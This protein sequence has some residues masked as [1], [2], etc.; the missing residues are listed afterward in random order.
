M[1]KSEFLVQA[2]KSG[3]KNLSV[4]GQIIDISG[5]TY[6][7][8]PGYTPFVEGECTIVA[9]PANYNNVLNNDRKTKFGIATIKV[10]SLGVLNPYLTT[11]IVFEKNKDL[12]QVGEKARFAISQTEGVN[13]AGKA[14]FNVQH[15]LTGRT[16]IEDL[17]FDDMG[18]DATID[19]A[20]N[21]EMAEK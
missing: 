16:T 13:E 5:L 18:K 6:H 1:T 17:L 10:T 8:N 12:I 9:T 4:G 15:Q 14:C 7:P 2:V 20:I 21:A 3:K 11:M 19:A